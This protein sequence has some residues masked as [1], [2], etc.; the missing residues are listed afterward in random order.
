LLQTNTAHGIDGDRTGFATLAA[1]FVRPG[2]GFAWD[3]GARSL[4]GHDGKRRRRPGLAPGFVSWRSRGI[5][6][7]WWSQSWCGLTCEP[8]SVEPLVLGWDKTRLK[9]LGLASPSPRTEG[10]HPGRAKREPGSGRHTQERHDAALFRRSA[11]VRAEVPGLH[12][13]TS[14]CAAPGMTPGP[15]RHWVGV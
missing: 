9:G 15:G 1:V 11:Y 14:C 3:D 2:G 7:W 12:R 8:T 4:L 5:L 10:C 13:I 6:A